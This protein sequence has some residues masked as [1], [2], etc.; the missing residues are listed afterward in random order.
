M[1]RENG[2]SPWIIR[3]YA[4]FGSAAETNS[5][6]RENLCSG[7]TGLSIAFDLP[8]QNGFDPDAPIARGEVGRTG[9]SIAHSGDMEV[10]L[11]EIDLARVNT[12]MTI[13]ATAPFI[14]ALYLVQAERAGTPWANLRGTVQNDL[15]KEFVARGTSVFSPAVSLRLSTDLIAF[16]AENVPQWN[17]VNVCGYHYMESGAGPSDEVGFAMANALLLLDAV[18]PRLSPDQFGTVVRRISFFINS[19]IEL[20]PEICKMRAYSTLWTDLCRSEYGIA[21][22]P[23]RA[24]CQVRSISLTAQQPENNIVRIALQALPAILSASARVNALQLPGFRE[25]LSL[26]DQAEQKLSIRTQQILMHESRITDYG[27][28]FAGNSIIENLTVEITEKAR[29]LAMQLRASGY[30]QTI[31]IVDQRLSEAIIAREERI[32]SGSE[33]VVGL[34]A[35]TDPVGLSEQLRTHHSD[36]Q[37]D[38]F[39]AGLLRRLQ[40][41]KL[42]RGLPALQDAEDILRKAVRNDE[43]IMPATIGFA[44]A[45]GT[46]GEWTAVIEQETNGRHS[47]HISPRTGDRQ[48]EEGKHRRHGSPPRLILAKAGLDG[49]TNGIKVL[50]LALRDAGVEVI[51]AGM[52][53][54][55][56][57]LVRMAIDEDASAIA[58]SSLSGAHMSIAGQL[59]DLRQ[60]HKLGDLKII[61]GGII[62]EEDCRRLEERGIDLVVPNTHGSFAQVVTQVCALLSRR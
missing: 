45:G 13:N 43:N 25:A 7:Q 1:P 51:F 11:G 49:H 35:F 10:L 55:P 32:H 41:W 58:I 12:S 20:V 39:E 50:A 28:I 48:R 18:R 2:H 30:E 42:R 8:T 23:F 57:A 60:R 22:V 47:R 15:L 5:R 44:R 29:T 6:F 31:A 61:L 26:P 38:A 4:G 59:T 33:I 54:T 34:N 17:P 24:G 16:T 9:V 3:T 27:D 36:T 53:L 62:P 21:D 19:G 46:V 37:D 56:E 52:K 14:L 40:E